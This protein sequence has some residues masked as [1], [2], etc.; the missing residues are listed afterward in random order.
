MAEEKNIELELR[1]SAIA[2]VM[3]GDPSLLFEAVGNLVD[4]AIKFTPQGGRVTVRTFTEAGR[5]GLE[6]GDTG[7][8]IAEKER[9]SVSLRFYRAV[10]S[11]NTPGT[12][13]GLALVAAVAR[14]HDMDLVIA[15]VM[16][17]C[18]ITLSRPIVAVGV[19]VPQNKLTQSMLSGRTPSE[20]VGSLWRL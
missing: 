6:V 2:T 19:A 17:G 15:D 9:E 20:T 16:P 10:E 14:L 18:C 11:R 3:P 1:L 12:G 13:L 8:G 7:P 4:N 5:V